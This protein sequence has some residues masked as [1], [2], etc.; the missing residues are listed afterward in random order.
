VAFSVSL[1]K[2]I[3]TIIISCQ[4]QELLRFAFAF[5]FAKF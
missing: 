4:I 3:L 2:Q 1:I 5:A